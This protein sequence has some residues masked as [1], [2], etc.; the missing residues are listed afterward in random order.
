MPQAS[1]RSISPTASTS[2]GERVGARADLVRELAQDARHLLALR[3]LGLPQPVRV[4]D[5]RERLDEQRLPGARA[6][7]DDPGHARARRRS[8]REDGSARTAR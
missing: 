3:A 1:A 5:D 7:V 8:Q 4:L 2:G 6:V